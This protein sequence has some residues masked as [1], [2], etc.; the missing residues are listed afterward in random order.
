MNRVYLVVSKIKEIARQQALDG[1]KDINYEQLVDFL[2][3]MDDK[4][5]LKATTDPKEDQDKRWE[6]IVV[7]M[8]NNPKLLMQMIPDAVNGNMAIYDNQKGMV[9]KRSRIHDKIQEAQQWQKLSKLANNF[10]ANKSI[11]K[12][13]DP[14]LDYSLPQA[15]FPEQNSS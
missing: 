14:N 4:E 6:Q 7:F 5:I 2:Q 9:M 3:H 13:D 10:M 8:R 15:P 11:Q 12:L 1:S